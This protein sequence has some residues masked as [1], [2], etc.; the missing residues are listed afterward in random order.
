MRVAP[1]SARLASRQRRGWPL[2]CVVSH[3]IRPVN[4]C[5]AVLHG[6]GCA[7]QRAVELVW[8]MNRAEMYRRLQAHAGPWDMIVVGG[9]AT[10]AGVAIDGASRSYDE[11]GRASGRGR[12]ESSV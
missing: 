12:E 4:S 11:I 9:G 7:R 1:S 5:D 10:G 8:P 6:P 3:S 2:G